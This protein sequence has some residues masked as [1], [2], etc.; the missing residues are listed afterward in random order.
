[1]KHIFLREKDNK[2][3]IKEQI[4]ILVN[5]IKNRFI[6]FII[7]V[8][9]IYIICLYY[10]ICFNSTYPNI[11]IEW[12]KSSIFLFIMRQFLYIFQCLFETS[13]RFISFHYES[14]KIF[15]AS[16]LFN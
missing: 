5:S 4:V 15:K 12:I 16:K 10:L 7:T 8:F 13:L 6:S 11:Q 3:K 9:F 1:M 2:N 14:E